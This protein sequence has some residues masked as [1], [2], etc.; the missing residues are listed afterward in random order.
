MYQPKAVPYMAKVYIMYLFQ[1]LFRYSVENK[2]FKCISYSHV[3]VKLSRLTLLRLALKRIP[4]VKRGLTVT[5]G[6]RERE[7]VNAKKENEL[8]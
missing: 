8:N 4:S 1:T 3:S 2:D 5:E 7:R 6:G